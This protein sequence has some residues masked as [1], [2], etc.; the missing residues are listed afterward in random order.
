[1]FRSAYDGP[2]AGSHGA[3]EAGYAAYT[4]LKIAKQWATRSGPCRYGTPAER[5]AGIQRALARAEAWL[6]E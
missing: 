1:V 6:S 4:W 3:A 5:Q 2:A